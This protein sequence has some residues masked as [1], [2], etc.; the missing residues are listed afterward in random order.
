MVM[1]IIS[2]TD[3]LLSSGI[4]PRDLKIISV[5]VGSMDP[6]MVTELEM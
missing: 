2:G 1:Q 6:M 5:L 3:F 4:I